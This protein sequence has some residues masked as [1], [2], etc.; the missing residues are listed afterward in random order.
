MISNTL[1]PLTVVKTPDLQGSLELAREKIEHFQQ[2]FAALERSI[3]KEVVGLETERKLLL[4]ALFAGGHVLFE[5]P[6]GVAKTLLAKAMSKSLGLESKRIQFTP[7]LMPSDITGTL[8]PS[9]DGGM[10]FHPGPIF[11]SVVIADEINRSGPKVQAA[12]LEAMAE[13]SVTTN[14]V[15]RPL[16]EVFMVVATQNPLESAGTYPLP[17]A[18]LDRFAVRIKVHTPSTEGIKAILDR[19]TKNTAQQSLAILE[20]DQ[21]LSTIS[22]FKGMVR[23]VEVS[24]EVKDALALIVVTLD[25]TSPEKMGNKLV[26]K[27]VA[28]ATAVR[29][30][31]SALLLA[32]VNA[33]LS[34]R[35]YVTLDDLASVTVPALAHRVALRPDEITESGTAEK[36]VKDVT[37]Q[38]IAHINKSRK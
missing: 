22:E 15:T 25:P 27:H 10:S 35:G 31:Q 3:A 21:V 1:P 6:P 16:P 32:K 13:A 37:T 24:E 17:D 20:P 28:S 19:T 11:S 4:S 9:G 29:G 7:D 38:V 5:G 2:T 12:L 36:V 33:L 14:G 34:G 26:E 30:A 8:I 18:Q 23:A